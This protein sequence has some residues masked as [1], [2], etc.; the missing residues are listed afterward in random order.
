[1]LTNTEKLQAKEKPV[2]DL[3]IK[4]LE[5]C[6]GAYAPVYAMLPPQVSNMIRGVERQQD[7]LVARLYNGE[8]T[9]GDFDVGMNELNG[10]LSEA[11]SGVSDQSK[12]VS[13][14]SESPKAVAPPQLQAAV[15]APAAAFHDERIALVIG[16][17]N[18]IN[19]PKLTNPANDAH[20][21]ADVL[22][23]MGY[24]TQLVLDASTDTIR[25][26]IRKFARESETADV[27]LVYYSGHGAQLSG[28]SYLLPTDMDIPRTAA[29]IQFTGLKIDDLVN[30]I[31]SNTKIVFIDACRDNPVL[32]KNI[33]SGR[34]IPAV[35]L[36]PASASNFNETKPGGGVFIAYATDAGAVAE[37]GHGQHSPFTQ[38]LLRYMRKPISIDDMFSLVTKDVRLVTKNE[39][40][41]YKY[42]SLEN[43]ICL[44]P[45]CSEMPTPAAGNII[46]QAQ[47]SETDELQIALKTK[48]PIA[49]ETYLTKYPETPKRT[50]VLSEI[51][52]LTRSEMK[53]WT[54]FEIGDQH[55][56]QYMQLS[57]IEKFGDRAA[58]RMKN[59][60]D[61]SK[62]KVWY[63]RSLPDAAYI[64]D[65]NVYDCT[66]PEMADA[67][68][69][70]FDKS[71][72]LL[73]HYKWG[74]PRY[75][76]LAI[77]VKLEPHSVGATA[78]N[79]V[80]H[81]DI[82]TPLVGK[83]E[84]AAMKF[85]SLASTP[86]GNGEIFYKPR[87]DENLQGQKAILF[88]VR[89]FKD[90]NVKDNFPQ[91]YS[92]PNPPN[93]RTEVDHVLLK[94]NANTFAI[95]RVE[96]WN[97]SNELVRIQVGD[98]AEPVKFSEFQPISLYATLQQIYCEKPYGGIGIRITSD[99]QS[100]DVAEVFSG[101][102]A[103]KAGVKQNDIITAIDN[104][105]VSGLALDEI[106]K[107]TRGPANTKVNLTISR[108]GQSGP[109][110]LLITRENVEM[111]STQLGPTK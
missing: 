34:G 25:D 70:I 72:Q 80:C 105:P 89:W 61:D 86:D 101:S 46:Q 53:E 37:D 9:F 3:A 60:V 30:S 8:I 54:L 64:E 28:S 76:N 66:K 75:I 13:V 65:L 16:N 56:P 33:V 50:E 14:A 83:A 27:A 45:E 67:D 96:Y 92:I 36:A 107:R 110:E 43:I 58:V 59:A 32:F 73:F 26:A 104:E 63:G 85:N 31:G 91:G 109:M 38:A 99:N 57:S 95:D 17:S 102:P 87:V 84:I 1:M 62:P 22:Q 106:I 40:R 82:G 7:D 47:Q 5:K 10:K 2:A 111:K 79:I 23:K 4:T 18:Y 20:S 100:I 49:L 48:N 42:A 90:H 52:A 68:D 81:E 12:T 93:Y 39:Q 15:T 29:D 77:G 69:S 103:E 97:A 71:G 78:Q 11:L 74:D 41:P 98:G 51:A 88:I 24:Q 55:L 19:L 6:R 108:A 44:T 94:C 35:G 21:I